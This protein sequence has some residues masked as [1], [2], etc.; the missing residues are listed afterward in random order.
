[1]RKLLFTVLV[2]LF[3]SFGCYRSNYCG[4]DFST[5]M[6][7]CVFLDEHNKS[8]EK[9]KIDEIIQLAVDV[10][11]ERYPVYEGEMYF[12]FATEEVNLYILKENNK[13]MQDFEDQ[14]IEESSHLGGL[15]VI[16]TRDPKINDVYIDY[17]NVY[18]I[19]DGHECIE[20]SSLPHEMI[21]VLSLFS[22]GLDWVLE[23]EDL[24]P[25]KYFGEDSP[26]SEVKAELREHCELP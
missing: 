16:A 14:M 19:W 17:V 20:K 21:H 5:D 24:H 7:V 9:D 8:V 18:I 12:G 25:K 11:A 10:I 26:E 4:G 2:S 23:L 1:M 13:L 3:F 6:G 22:E 15:T